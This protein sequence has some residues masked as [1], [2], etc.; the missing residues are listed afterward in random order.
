[1]AHDPHPYQL[2]GD[3][4]VTHLGHFNRRTPDHDP[5][6]GLPVLDRLSAHLPDDD[7]DYGRACSVEDLIGIIEVGPTQALVLGDDP[8]ATT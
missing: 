4:N 6:I 8:A 5:E 7:G 3:R 1:M 2:N